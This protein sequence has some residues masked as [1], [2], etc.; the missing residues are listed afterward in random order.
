MSYSE[1]EKLER[2]RAS[3]AVGDLPEWLA[4]H[5]PRIIAE[6]DAEIAALRA[7]IANSLIGGEDGK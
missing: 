6:L 7:S 5:A 2:R 4:E 3:W 1:L